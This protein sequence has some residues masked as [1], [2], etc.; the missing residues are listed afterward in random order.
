MV[1]VNA[2]DDPAATLTVAALIETEIEDEAGADLLHPA[3]SAAETISVRRK[4]REAW[5]T[6][7]PPSPLQTR[8]QRK[9]EDS[10]A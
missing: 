6:M 7:R 9:L 10:T 1:A 8:R 5:Q 4:T 3:K 2:C